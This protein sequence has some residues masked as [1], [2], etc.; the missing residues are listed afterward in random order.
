MSLAR[1]GA[2]VLGCA[3]LAGCGTDAKPAPE[4]TAAPPPLP[5]RTLYVQVPLSGPAA[6]E[7][8]AMLDAVRLVVG[9][10][11]GLAGSV[12]VIVRALD[13]GGAGSAAT[14]PGRCADNAATAAADPRALAV[15]GTYELACSVRA[16]SV[17]QPAGLLLV[18]PL[19]A[20]AALPGALRLAPTES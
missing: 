2:A 18:S 13:D 10:H 3:L 14:D 5:Q 17:L 1:A 20:A 12:R 19:N 16:L 6:G 11:G 4:T 9:Q 8:R 15:I 7:G